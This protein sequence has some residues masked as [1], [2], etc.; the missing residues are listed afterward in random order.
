MWTTRASIICA[1]VATEGPVSF[2]PKGGSVIAVGGVAVSLLGHCTSDNRIALSGKFCLT[3]VLALVGW[4]H[5]QAID[6]TITKVRRLS[7]ARRV[8]CAGLLSSSVRS[9]R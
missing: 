2:V 7:V 9:S 5:H 8:A 6:L 4:V 3:E 1:G